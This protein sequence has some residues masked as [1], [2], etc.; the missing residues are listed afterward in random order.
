MDIYC[1]HKFGLTEFPQYIERR[2][3]D[4]YDIK[5]FEGKCWT[6][7]EI[8]SRKARNHGRN[9]WKLGKWEEFSECSANQQ[10]RTIIFLHICGHK[11]F[12]SKL[13]FN[14]IDEANNYQ[15][16]RSH[17]ASARTI[18]ASKYLRGEDPWSLQDRREEW[19]TWAILHHGRAGQKC[20]ERSKGMTK[21]SKQVIGA[22]LTTF[23][24]AGLAEISTSN[25]GCFWLCAVM[26]SVGLAMCLMGYIHE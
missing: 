10:D 21:G 8:S 5:G 24:G 17:D 3:I 23:G 4:G 9:P 2:K 12:T 7:P 13:R 20:N 22:V 25:H 11:F 14:R 16:S 26:F 18:S 19:Q 6:R 15:R 1:N